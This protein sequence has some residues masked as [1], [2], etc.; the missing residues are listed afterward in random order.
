M[1]EMKMKK[2]LTAG[3]A[4]AAAVAFGEPVVTNSSEL[5]SLTFDARTIVNEIRILNGVD[6]LL[7]FAYFDLTGLDLPP[8]PVDLLR[9]AFGETV[10][11]TVAANGDPTVKMTEDLT[12]PVSVPSEVGAFT[13]DVNGNTLSGTNGVDGTAS[14]PGTDGYA[15][16]SK[17]FVI[18]GE[19]L[20]GLNVKD[21][22][23]KVNIELVP[24]AELE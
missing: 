13:L 3:L 10:E 20:F 17:C 15:S 23:A 18:H 12:G 4:L 11:I 8:D 22:K 2:V 9:T 6:E 19:E 7:A 14:T 1:K 24:V 16:L 5:T 21:S